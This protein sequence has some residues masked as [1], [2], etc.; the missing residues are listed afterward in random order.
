[1]AKHCKVNSTIAGV[2]KLEEMATEGEVVFS[3]INVNDCVTKSKFGD[4][5]SCRS[6]LIDVPSLG[7]R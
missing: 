6:L 4:V 2:P 1:M 5:H 7:A 3:V